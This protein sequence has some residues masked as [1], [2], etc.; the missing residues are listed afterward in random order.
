MKLCYQYKAKPNET[1][2]GRLNELLRIA[3][4][5]YNEALEERMREWEEMKKSREGES[6]GGETKKVKFPSWYDMNKWWVVRRKEDNEYRRLNVQAGYNVLK[7]LHL[8]LKRFLV[9]MKDKQKYGFPEPKDVKDFRTLEFNYGNGARILSVNGRNSRLYIQGVGEIKFIMH[10]PIPEQAK[11]KQVRITRKADGWWIGFVLDV[12]E[13]VLKK[14]LP[15]TGR[16][17]GIDVG[18]ENLLTFSSGEMIDNPRWLKNAEKKIAK[19]QKILS[20]RQIGS[21][22]WKKLSEEIAKWHLKISRQRRNFYFAT[23]SSL[24]A[25]YDTICVENLKIQDMAQGFLRKEV[26]DAGWGLFLGNILPFK[27]WKACRELKQV[28]PNGTS[29]LCAKCGNLVPKDLSVREHVCPHCGFSTHRDF[30]S[31]LN[32]LKMGLGEEGKEIFL[33]ELARFEEKM[34]ERGE[35]SPL[36]KLHD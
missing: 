2:K 19:K 9:A 30:N 28:N 22:R 12:P 27:V 34:K 25:N 36:N 20:R 7:R 4:R 14:P 24:V 32:V 6:G 15:P 21:K 35:E 11:I 31:A 29:Q 10:R 8:A 16:A 33:Q 5:L 23:A 1:A 17:V 26:R 18:I 3:C 13:E